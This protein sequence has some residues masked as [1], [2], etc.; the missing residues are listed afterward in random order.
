L[1]SV[2]NCLVYSIKIYTLFHFFKKVDLILRIKIKI[3]TYF[4]GYTYIFVKSSI[5]ILDITDINFINLYVK[6]GIKYLK[7]NSL[8]N[9]FIK[10]G[11]IY[12]KRSKKYTQKTYK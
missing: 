12:S 11:I 10:L 6:L 3:Y 4:L 7:K 2:K 5:Y 9:T 8:N 1:F